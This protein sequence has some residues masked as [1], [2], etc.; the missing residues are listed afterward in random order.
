MNNYCNKCL[1]FTKNRNTV[2]I[3]KIDFKNFETIDEEELSLY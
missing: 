2:L 1:M 3:L